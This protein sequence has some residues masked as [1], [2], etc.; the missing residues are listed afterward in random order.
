MSISLLVGLSISLLAGLG[1]R[2]QLMSHRETAIHSNPVIHS[3][4]PCCLPFFF[5]SLL[6]VAGTDKICPKS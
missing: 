3:L 5:M 4:I 2:G 1:L 6:H